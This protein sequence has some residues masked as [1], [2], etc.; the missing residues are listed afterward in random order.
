MDSNL[1]HL[2]Y[3]MTS[4]SSSENVNALTASNASAGVCDD[5]VNSSSYLYSP[6]SWLKL[7]SAEAMSSIEL[8]FLQVL[9]K[10]ICILKFQ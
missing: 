7:Y 8:S 10:Y 3:E 4:R 1:P 6:G 9:Q 2:G 5:I